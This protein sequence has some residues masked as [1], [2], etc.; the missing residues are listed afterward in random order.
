MKAV[1]GRLMQLTRPPP[2]YEDHL[3]T[4]SARAARLMAWACTAK[5]VDDVLGMS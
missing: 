2:G 1:H 5:Y 3:P 4:W